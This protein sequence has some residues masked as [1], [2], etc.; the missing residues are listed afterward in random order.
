MNMM[1]INFHSMGTPLGAIRGFISMLTLRSHKINRGT[2]KLVGHPRLLL[3]GIK[4][5]LTPLIERDELH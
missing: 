2:Y 3:H 1:K 5:R 4:V